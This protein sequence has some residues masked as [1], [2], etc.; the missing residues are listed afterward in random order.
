MTARTHYVIEYDSRLGLHWL[1]LTSHGMARGSRREL[2][3]TAT[4]E[5]AGTWRDRKRADA[6]CAGAQIVFPGARVVAVEVTP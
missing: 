3:M 4:P 2:T 6:L 1:R 5:R